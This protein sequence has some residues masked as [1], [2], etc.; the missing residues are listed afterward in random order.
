MKRNLLRGYASLSSLPCL[1]GYL[2]VRA[3]PHPDKG[4]G[5]A[6]E[7]RVMRLKQVLSYDRQF[8]GPASAPTEPHIRRSVGTHSL[9]RQGAHISKDLIKLQFLGK[10]KE[11][12]T[13]I[14]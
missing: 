5:I 4:P 6:A 2:C 12:W 10:S 13:T 8:Q 3:S 7:L 1:P 9:G 11:D 14:W